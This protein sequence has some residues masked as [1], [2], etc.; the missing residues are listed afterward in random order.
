MFHHNNLF[1][2]NSSNLN[3]GRSCFVYSD[4]CSTSLI[5]PFQKSIGDEP[6][7]YT[8][9]EMKALQE[10][11]QKQRIEIL[12]NISALKTT[13]KSAGL[14]KVDINPDNADSGAKKF[15]E[16]KVPLREE[17]QSLDKY[18]VK[19]TNKKSF[20][21]LSK[22]DGKVFEETLSKH[23]S[24]V[25]LGSTVPPTVQITSQPS[26]A[27]SSS[28][29]P[30]DRT[31][32]K[33]CVT[34]SASTKSGASVDEFKSGNES[35][36]TPTTS[37]PIVVS[38]D[39]EDKPTPE[40]TSYRS[41]SDRMAATATLKDHSVHSSLS[42]NAIRSK[43]T[44]TNS[45]LGRSSYEPT[46]SY[47]E[48]SLSSNNKKQ[49]VYHD[50][51][52]SIYESP[53]YQDYNYEYSD[54]SSSKGETTSTNRSRAPAYHDPYKSLF[55]DSYSYETSSGYQSSSRYSSSAGS[56]SYGEI[57]IK[58]RYQSKYEGKYGEKDKFARLRQTEGYES[59]A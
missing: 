17:D 53:N 37:S 48:R 46:T 55:D 41:Y 54:S 12:R 30:A 44:D 33:K 19:E 24:S 16:Y 56:K 7:L 15:H 38:V 10:Q 29:E 11:Q 21:R 5:L 47:Q 32:F 26:S 57:E 25:S 18:S 31:S 6:K 58:S 40:S 2:R 43:T 4:F 52:K 35:W 23:S 34:F 51:Y 3:F 45:Y 36:L 9:A 20:P 8:T 22:D 42:S 39:V 13:L 27:D 49:D 59:D 1:E 50:P 14:K 28:H